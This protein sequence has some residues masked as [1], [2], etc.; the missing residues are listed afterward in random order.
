ME[1][2]K[3]YIGLDVVKFILA[4]LV[5]MRHIIQVFFTAESQ[6]HLWIGSWL[7]NLAVPAFFVMSGF[8]LFRKVEAGQKDSAV[9]KAYSLKI[10]RMY[11]IW[12]ALYLPIEWYN[13]SHSDTGIREA[14]LRYIQSFFFASSIAQLWYLPALLTACLLVWFCYT[15]GMKIWQILILSF[16]FFLIGYVGDNWYLNEMLSHSTYLKLLEYNKY[17]LTM[18]NGLFYG[19][20]Y[21]A[22][23]LWFAKHRQRL[24]P[25]LAAV[26]AVLFIMLMYCEVVRVH[27]TN[28]L[29][30]AIPAVICLFMAASAVE[31]KP[32]AI[33][34]RLRIMSEWIYLSHFYF[35]YL[36]DWIR[37]WKPLPVNNKTVMVIVLGPILLFSWGMTRLSEQKTFRWLKRLI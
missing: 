11:L 10:I 37:P 20:F 1:V 31:G 12:S 28:I 29:I 18:R 32:Q 30:T 23:G 9:I 14:V 8:F 4:I 7:S 19:M 33:Y 24:H 3:Q 22:V 27:N 25:I 2:K 16:G 6:G 26:G 21:V 34:P 17:F 35:F 36:F 15:R 13:W 5:A